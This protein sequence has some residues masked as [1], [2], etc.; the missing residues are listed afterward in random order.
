M[1]PNPAPIFVQETV[2]HYVYLIV[3][4][5]TQKHYI[6]ITSDLRQR[7]KRHN[8]SS[9]AKFTKAGNWQ[10]VYYEAFLSKK[11]AYQRERK[12]KQDG[13]GRR[14]LYQRVA[15]CLTGQK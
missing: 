14:L 4:K 5:G 9:G 1:S 6:G 11:D 3:E 15:N 8:N 10:L 12:L 2:M 7:L 13:R